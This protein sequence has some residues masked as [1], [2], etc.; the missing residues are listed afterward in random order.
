[1]VAVGNAVGFFLLQAWFLLVTEQ[2]LRRSRPDGAHGRDLP[3]RHPRI[4]IADL[5]AT[6]DSSAP[7][8]SSS[9]RSQWSATS[10]T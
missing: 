10:P 2:V 7:S 6:A 4:G 8:R 3:W 9:R 1:V 5:L